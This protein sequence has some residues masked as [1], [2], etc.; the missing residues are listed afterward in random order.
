MLLCSACLE[1]FKT[2][3]ITIKHKFLLRYKVTIIKIIGS[4]HVLV[5]IN[6]YER[7]TFNNQKQSLSLYAHA[8]RERWEIIS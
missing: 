4:L 7:I 2:K 5:T 6:I 8:I 1:I 3:L